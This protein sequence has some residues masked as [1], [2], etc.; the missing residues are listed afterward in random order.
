MAIGGAITGAANNRIL[1]SNGSGNL[2]QQSTW[3]FDAL[4]F[5]AAQPSAQ[6]LRTT[7]GGGGYLASTGGGVLLGRTDDGPQL[8]VGFYTGGGP[9]VH[10]NSGYRFGN[11]PNDL[12]LND[13]A[14]TR[15]AADLI[16]GAALAMRAYTVATLPDA[17]TWINAPAI[18]T[19]EV[20]GRVPVF[21]DGTNWRR[22][23]D[24]AIAS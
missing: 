4:A 17:A 16:E 24:R 19:N 12:R 13:A 22:V 15:R 2:A 3:Y 14:I 7:D 5:G 18:C 20:G 8:F 23:T 21:S 10:V 11:N 6:C 1:Q 9:V